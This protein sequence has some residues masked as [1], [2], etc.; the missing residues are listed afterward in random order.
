MTHAAT[1]Q[2]W[3]VALIALVAALTLVLLTGTPQ[4]R[5]V[6]AQFLA[7]FRGEQIAAMS[8]ST[9][10][11]ANIEQ[12]LSDLQHLGSI[13][14]IDT[15]PQPRAVSSV[16]EASQF[17]GFPVLVPDP[18]ALP[19]GIDSAP[20]EVR[21]LPAHQARFTFDLERA[22]A[23]YQSIGRG[24][25][26][27]PERFNGAALVVNTPPAVLLQYRSVDATVDTPFSGLVVGQSGALTA[28][29]E[30]DVTLDE[31]REFLLG[32]P[33]LSPETAQ[34]LRDIDEWETTLPVP[35]PVEQIAW[36]RATIAGSPGLLLNDNT[37]MG[38][39]AI[40]QRDG[41]IFGM[42]GGMKA[43]ELQR[44]AESLR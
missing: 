22:R 11:I 33:G 2:R 42:A 43:R 3:R 30:G 1:F 20:A 26:A 25:V 9:D 24:D 38:S 4:G 28:S 39:A 36:E 17:V 7:Q 12:T 44:V 15:A 21:V 19:A 16:S 29:V 14:G 18:A 5:G 34:Q 27:L 32:L 35:I 6:G 8:V 23:Y 40:W 41:R 10:E 37:G 13:S 31:L